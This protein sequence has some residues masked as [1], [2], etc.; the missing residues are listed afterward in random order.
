VA[1]HAMPCH[2]PQ[3]VMPQL[4]VY[5]NKEKVGQIE[6]VCPGLSRALGSTCAGACC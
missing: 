5:K 2:A 1:G 4:K 6:R 3:D